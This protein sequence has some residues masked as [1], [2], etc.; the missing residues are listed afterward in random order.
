MKSIYLLLM[1][2]DFN[3]ASPETVFFQLSA[4][5]FSPLLIPAAHYPLAISNSAW[6]YPSYPTSKE[7][8]EQNCNENNH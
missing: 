8:D 7:S 1:R 5:T 3:Q 6:T 4:H 2:Q